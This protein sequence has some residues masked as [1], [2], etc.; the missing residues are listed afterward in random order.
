[1]SFSALKLTSF[2]DLQGYFLPALSKELANALA[3]ERAASLAFYR[4]PD[5]QRLEETLKAFQKESSGLRKAELALAVAQAVDG[6]LDKADAFVW[7]ENALVAHPTVSSQQAV[8]V[9]RG[10][11]RNHLAIFADLVK[12]RVDRLAQR[13]PLSPLVQVMR[14][15]LQAYLERQRKGQRYLFP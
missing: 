10:I 12:E 11:A 1:V 5:P 3:Q 9:A 8:A 7:L 15:E 14:Q 4:V 6:P 2:V 13:F